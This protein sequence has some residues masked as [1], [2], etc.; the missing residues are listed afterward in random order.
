MQM[1][2]FMILAIQLWMGARMLRKIFLEYI[3]NK[4]TYEPDCMDCVV[5]RKLPDTTVNPTFC[6]RKAS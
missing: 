3:F 5:W 2:G 4:K 1:I 6:E